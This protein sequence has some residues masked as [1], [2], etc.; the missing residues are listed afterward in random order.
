MCNEEHSDTLACSV[1]RIDVSQVS[2]KKK[3]TQGTY[4]NTRVLLLLL[5]TGCLVTWENH[6]RVFSLP[7]L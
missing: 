3:D 5:L 1:K 4:P 6:V 7:T 2:K